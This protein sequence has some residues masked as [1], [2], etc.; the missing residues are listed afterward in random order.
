MPAELDRIDTADL[1][2][3]RIARLSRP[4]SVSTGSTETAFTVTS[5]SWPPGPGRGSSTSNESAGIGDGH[6]LPV[7]SGLT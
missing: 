3:R 7:G 2:E 5:R 4:T 6:R 1:D